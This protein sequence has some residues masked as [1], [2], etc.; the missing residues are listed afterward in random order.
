MKWCRSV[1]QS[2]KHLFQFSSP[3]CSGF[4]SY[5]TPPSTQTTKKNEIQRKANRGAI[6]WTTT[7][8]RYQM[9]ELYCT[10]H[11][12]ISYKAPNY[13]I[14]KNISDFNTVIQLDLRS[15]VIDWRRSLI[16]QTP[17]VPYSGTEW[18][19]CSVGMCET[20]P[21]HLSLFGLSASFDDWTLEPR[22][23]RRNFEPLT[24]FSYHILPILRRQRCSS[25]D[26]LCKYSVLNGYVLKPHSGTEYMVV[27]SPNIDRKPNVMPTLPMFP[28]DANLASCTREDT[29]FSIWQPGGMQIP[30]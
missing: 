20:C 19:S 17:C 3:K 11:L 22:T 14:R 30:K 28:T 13:R 24:N 21:N 8:K 18:G 5:H 1:K 12:A 26:A 15:Q 16:F 23:L 2:A 4:G 25:T 6:S 7:K 27:V 10:Q 9:R 29:T